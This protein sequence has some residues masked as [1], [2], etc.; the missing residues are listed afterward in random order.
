M[1][2][3]PYYP[4][5]IPTNLEIIK[6]GN[7]SMAITLNALQAIA[8]S[9]TGYSGGPAVDDLPGIGL[10]EAA[11]ML[12]VAIMESS[13]EFNEIRSNNITALTE[14]TVNAISTGSDPDFG[15]IVEATWADLKAKIK[16]FFDK[17]IKFL[18]SIIAKLKVQMDKITKSGRQ[19]YDKYKDR[20]EY[21]GKNFK[22]LTVS[23]Y[24]FE[25]GTR[26]LGD[27]AKYA[28]ES[29]IAAMFKA[30]VGSEVDDPKTIAAGA[31]Y[32]TDSNEQ[33]A[34]KEK[35]SK[36]TDVSTSERQFKM[37]EHVVGSLASL[38][39]GS[40]SSD[41]RKELWGEKAEMKY[42][43]DCFKDTW[44][45]EMLGKDTILK[46]ITDDYTKMRKAAEDYNKSLQKRVDEI[47]KTITANRKSKPA[48]YSSNTDEGKRE[49][50]RQHNEKMDQ[51]NN[52]QSDVS[53]YINAYM[54][55]VSDAYGVITS[56]KNIELDYEKARLAQAKSFFGKMLSYN[57]KK[58]NSDSADAEDL[59]LLDADL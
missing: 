26:P 38:S 17:I 58:N 10:Y 24:K 48:S 12:P 31:G 6:G 39:E 37:A 53:A 27:V 43:E 56:L 33:T 30:A 2:E 14:A 42:G 45:S 41:L 54:G 19:L 46:S 34:A 1:Q 23:G 9:A 44:I 36:I 55:L 21:R 51:A 22:D 50:D 15:P 52:A 32:A 4:K 7:T 3:D 49:E 40:W 28:E 57:E 13:Q 25:H 29:N 20:P 8:E 35:I 16:K 18:N 5:T 59:F 11:G 47:E